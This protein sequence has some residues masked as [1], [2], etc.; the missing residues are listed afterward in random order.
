MSMKSDYF[1]AN[2]KQVYP[3]F[4]KP[5]PLE[6][7]IWEELLEPYREETIRRGI[8]SYR[9]T[10]DS[11]YAPTPAK[12]GEYLY[13]PNVAAKSKKP[14]DDLPLCPEAY[15]IKQD[16]KAGR[17]KH[18]FPTYANAVTYLLDVKTKEV[19]KPEDYKKS[20]RFQ[21]YR[22]AVDNGL[23][24]NFD[25]TLDFVAKARGNYDKK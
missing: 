23:F 18:L 8:K 20:T 16:I 17:C 21:R 6:V 12:F 5:S 22:F 13:E 10:V 24:A 4:P 15:L 19:M 3:T 11:P 7:E 25:Q 1:F 9:K 2:I 14:D